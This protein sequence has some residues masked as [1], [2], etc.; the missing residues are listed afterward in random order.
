MVYILTI[1]GS[2]W[3]IITLGSVYEKNIK[4]EVKDLEEAK[5]VCMDYQDERYLGSRD[6]KVSHGNVSDKGKVIAR[7][8]YNG[9]IKVK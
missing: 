3:M 1:T 5:K 8:C 4:V 7:I 2:Y 6:L 9:T